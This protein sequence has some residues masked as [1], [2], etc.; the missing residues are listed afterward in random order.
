MNDAPNKYADMKD[1][2]LNTFKESENICI[3]QLL[4][5]LKLCHL[6]SSR[7]KSSHLKSSHL[8]SRP[9]KCKSCSWQLS[10]KLLP[11]VESVASPVAKNV[12]CR[13]YR[14]VHDKKK[15]VCIF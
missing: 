6:K 1:R 5:G 7:L 13:N 4:T 9:E 11:A 10:A 15:L 3:K 8:K 2:L 12:D 14:F